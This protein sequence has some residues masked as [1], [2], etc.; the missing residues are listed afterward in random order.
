M[1]KKPVDDF[2]LLEMFQLYNSYKPKSKDRG[3]VIRRFAQETGLT[4]V[5]VHKL[6]NELKDGQDLHSVAARKKKIT[7]LSPEKLEKQKHVIETIAKVKYMDQAGI[8]KYLKTNEQAT[9]QAVNMGLIKE[10]DLYSAGHIRKLLKVAGLN[11]KS[12][13]RV[14]A[15]RSWDKEAL[16]PNMLWMTDASPANRVYINK[17][18]K[19]I[20]PEVDPSDEHTLSKMIHTE[21]LRKVHIYIFVDVFSGCWFAKAFASDPIGAK[22]KRAGENHV[23]FRSAFIEATL[24]K[25]NGINPFEGIPQI[26]Y[27]DKGSAFKPLLPF[28]DKLE[29]EYMTHL[30]GNPK[31]KGYA[32]GGISVI[33][34]SIETAMSAVTVRDIDDFNLVLHN[35][36]LFINQKNGNYDRFLAGSIKNPIRRLTQKNISDSLSKELERV[37]DAYGCVSV[38]NR[39]LGVHAE[40]VGVKVKL[41]ERKN[42]WLAKDPE[43]NVYECDNNGKVKNSIKDYSMYRIDAD[44]N[45]VPVTDRKLSEK[46]Q[47]RQRIK[48]EGKLLART[49]TIDDILHPESNLRRFPAANFTKDTH[50]TLAPD[51]FDSVEQALTYILTETGL[52]AN[53]IKPELFTQIKSSLELMGAHEK[54]TSTYVYKLVNILNKTISRLEAINEK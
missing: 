47:T 8:K 35:K 3:D 13:S 2:Y 43:G 22:S 36:M 48:E 39:L 33:K 50:S 42:I 5:T 45:H 14:L 23:D 26:L 16:T 51:E 32:E 27:S 30:P 25:Y 20:R 17:S 38:N 10:E 1:R 40:L 7:R 12:Y 52:R 54:I 28:F 44:G 29:I 34:R 18:G 11:P 9:M 46:E 19:V 6:F 4:D 53:E 24:P 41:F 37:V 49:A 31:A 15:C 21:N